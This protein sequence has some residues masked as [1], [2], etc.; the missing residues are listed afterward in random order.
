MAIAKKDS[1][2]TIGEFYTWTNPGPKD[3]GGSAVEFLHAL[4]GPTHIHI[5]GEDRSR[6]RAVVT[7]LHGNEPSGLHAI[8]EILKRDIQAVVDIHYF[9]LNVDAARQAPG[10]IYRMLPQHKDINRCFRP[11][12][13]DSEPSLLAQSLLQKL[14][15]FQPECTID[16]HNTSGS[17]PSF[18]VT[19]FMDDLH[20][21]LV[22]LFTHRMIVTDLK[23]GALM[24][25]SEEVM[26]TVTI[27]CGGAQDIES[28]IIATEGLTRYITIEDILSRQ[29]GDMTLEF[30]H[31]PIRL[32]LQEGQDIVYGDH[33]LLE[34]GVTLLP[35]MENYNFGFVDSSTH[36]GFVSGGLSDTLKLEGNTGKEQISE[37]FELRDK[38]LY[39]CKR[40]KLFMV[41][42]NPEIASKDCLFYFAEPD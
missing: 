5:T 17:S 26:P 10:F 28:H 15:E 7:L 29:H 39:P 30:F 27:E 16:I 19:T 3:I 8:Y 11:P 31:N 24:E 14:L 32:E 9:I 42:S 25:I 2:I 33:C 40:L 23:L 4:P 1:E 37:Y 18:G 6:S 34:Q 21:A 36:L 22:S 35:S 20:D 13:D 41:T 38:E 12:Y